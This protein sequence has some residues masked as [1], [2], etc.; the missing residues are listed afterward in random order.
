M[1]ADNKKSKGYDSLNSFNDRGVKSR[2]QQNLRSPGG[3][4]KKIEKTEIEKGIKK[5]TEIESRERSSLENPI[6][7]T[8]RSAAE[9][10]APRP[11][12]SAES[13]DPIK[14]IG[15]E[16]D[17]IQDLS[18]SKFSFSES[19]KLDKQKKR[20]AKDEKLLSNDTWL[21]RNGHNLTYLGLY[22]FSFW[23]FFRPYELIPGLGFLS[24]VAFY[25]AV[26]TLAI[27]LPTQFATEGNFS[28]LSTEVKCILSIALLAL[29]TMPIAKSPALAWETFNDNFI[30]A[31]LMFIVMVNVLRTRKRLLALIWLSISIGLY[32][33]FVAWSMY[34]RGEFT[35]EGT[36]VG[37]EFGGMF[38]NPNDMALHLVI[39]TPIVIVLGIASKSYM[40]RAV[41]FIT[42]WFLVLGNMVTFSRGGF[43]GLLTVSAVLAWKLGRKYRLNTMIATVIIGFLFIVFAPGEYGQRILS[44]FDSSL[45]AVG[46][47]NQRTALLKRSILVSIRNPWGIGIGNFPIVGFRHLGTHNAYTQ[48]SSEIGF[49]GF[50]AYLIFLVSPLRKLGA[51]ERMVLANNKTGWFYYLSIGLQASLAGFMVSSFFAAVAYNWFIYY[52]IAY[53]VAFR[54]IYKI[55]GGLN[56]EIKSESGTEKVLGLQLKST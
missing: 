53:A 34:L 24:P 39:V 49:L 10:L 18:R 45:D 36:R 9:N 23:V 4:S 50:V 25:I 21:K 33:S 55:E 15:N 29:I 52:L 37:L 12:R 11:G 32:L 22:L 41:Y 38:G 42:A 54:R 47:S 27:Y 28:V 40:M 31:V 16:S 3:Q 5:H 30:K 56:E 1:S 51:I 13:N 35:V 43:L 7:S 17:E 20:S 2:D 6:K 26:A 48:V 19:Q 44:I 14:R 46:S 8:N